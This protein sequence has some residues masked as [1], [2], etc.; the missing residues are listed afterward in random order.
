MTKLFLFALIDANLGSDEFK[1][2][3]QNTSSFFK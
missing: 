3:S 1:A 2:A